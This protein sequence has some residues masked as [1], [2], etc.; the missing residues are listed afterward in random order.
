MLLHELCIWKKKK[1][2]FFFY[3]T[4]SIKVSILLSG[5]GH[6]HTIHAHQ[7]IRELLH[8]LLHHRRLLLFT[9]SYVCILWLRVSNIQCTKWAM[10]K[11]F[12][13]SP[14]FYKTANMRDAGYG[15]PFDKL[16]SRLPFSEPSRWHCEP[17]TYTTSA[18]SQCYLSSIHCW[19][20]E[21]RAPVD[22]LQHLQSTSLK[23]H[24]TLL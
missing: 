20:S 13:K 11:V 4:V 19:K 15:F 22:S 23:I 16:T 9:T 5:T 17:P 3:R 10:Y 21:L 8:I 6:I 14:T 18:K 1:K 24:N 2:H 7:S 12:S